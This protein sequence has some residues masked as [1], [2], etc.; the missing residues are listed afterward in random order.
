VDCEWVADFIDPDSERLYGF[1][2]S[3]FSI[4]K[5]IP[6]DGTGFGIRHP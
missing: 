1:T 4:K 2:T 3:D 5:H 6:F